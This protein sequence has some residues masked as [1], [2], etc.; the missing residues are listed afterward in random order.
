MPLSHPGQLTRE[1][2]VRTDAR[3]IIS[4]STKYLNKFILILGSTRK[5]WA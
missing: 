2:E 1:A 4:T 3:A 5:L